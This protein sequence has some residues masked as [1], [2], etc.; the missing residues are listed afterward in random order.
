MERRSMK[1]LIKRLEERSQALF[2]WALKKAVVDYILMDASERVRIKIYHVPKE[3]P[4]HVI[5]GPIPWHNN[6]V[7]SRDIIRGT[8]YL[9]HP[10]IVAIRKIWDERYRKIY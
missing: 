2:K 4:L 8:L 5:R 9:S 6:F 1:Y 3:F 7:T 10:V